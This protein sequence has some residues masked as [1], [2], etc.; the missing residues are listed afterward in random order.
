MKRKKWV[1]YKNIA[2]F[3]NSIIDYDQKIA[4]ACR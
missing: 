3:Q 1:D 2:H 4:T